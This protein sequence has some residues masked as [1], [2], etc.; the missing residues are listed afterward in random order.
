MMKK[1]TKTGIVLAFLLMLSALAV[2][3]IPA[4]E[5][6]LSRAADYDNLLVYIESD[7]SDVTIDETETITVNIRVSGVPTG[8]SNTIYAMG[9]YLRFD[10]AKFEYSKFNAANTF[11]SAER[12]L[13]SYQVST[14][15]VSE[16]ILLLSNMPNS[17]VTW[18][19]TGILASLVFNV[20]ADTAGSAVFEI[21]EALSVENYSHLVN[22]AGD[23]IP[24]RAS[25]VQ[26]KVVNITGG[27]EPYVPSTN[28]D[29]FSLSISGASNWTPVFNANTL[30]YSCT[31]P[32]TV[33]S[34]TVNAAA[35]DGL[36]SVNV[37][38]ADNLQVGS[39]SVTV[40]VTAE[41]GITTKTYS[42][43]VTRE[44]AAVIPS[45]NADLSSLSISGASSW[46]PTFSP[47]V[48]S[49]SCIVP[50]SMTN[51]NVIAA[52]A[53]SKAKV[54]IFDASDLQVG[55]N[56]VTVLVTAEDG[57]STKA[58][59]I[60]ITR[61]APP[62]VELSNNANLSSLS[63]NGASNWSPTF[64]PG[65]TGYSCTVPNS[66]A[67]VTVNYL[68]EQGGA[69]ASI[70]GANN[71]Q[72]G[73]NTVTVT[74][75]AEDGISKKTYTISVTREGSSLSNN[76]NL[77]SLSINNASNWSP[78]FNPSTTVY[79]C[80]VP[81]SI[82]NAVVN[83][84]REH[85]NATAN[86][87]GA[88][89]LQV[90]M[91]TVTVTVTAED[92]VATKIYTISVTREASSGTEKSNNA[93]LSILSIFGASNWSPSF[94]KNTTSYYCT[95]PNNISNV[96]VSANKEHANATVEIH[97]ANNLVVG[98]NTVTVL[99]T[100]ED[101][102]TKTYTI[103]VVRLESSGT[104]NPNN[105]NQISIVVKRGNSA[106]NIAWN[107]SSYSLMS[108]V[109]YEDKSSLT[110]KVSKL[111]P[112]YS[113]LGV[114]GSTAVW[115]EDYSL[116]LGIGQNFIFVSYDYNDIIYQYLLKIVVDE[117]V[118]NPNPTSP[119]G[120]LIGIVIKRNGVA[121]NIAR[122]GSTYSL[123]S[124]V[125]YVDR[126]NITVKINPLITGNAS[127][128]IDG[129]ASEWS[130]DYAVNLG[131]GQNIII[132]LLSYEDLTY[133]YLIKIIVAEDSSKAAPIENPS[134]ISEN[135]WLIIALVALG[136]IVILLFVRSGQRPVSY[137]I[138]ESSSPT[139]RKAKE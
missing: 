46:S 77:S 123:M 21:V 97:G 86:V 26:N 83:Y 126:N 63:I 14:S 138:V 11:P 76:A 45:A 118:G 16:G 23:E 87:S 20:T 8:N 105:L 120:N 58:Y 108:T 135:L 80:T 57:T 92:G 53:D 131:V 52:K 24:V 101:G 47:N 90:G 75:T 71:L 2:F 4:Q 102:T 65:T 15:M 29:L 133:Q 36:A 134:I 51:A 6:V 106:L 69:T 22:R 115:G 61:Q 12:I 84:T 88:N 73:F 60:N 32:N 104:E 64:N 93:N 111:F 114:D 55:L 124:E 82:V 19:E 91:N 48:L 125:A 39:N 67:S 34:L 112:E 117:P 110:L 70:S 13:I 98:P 81:N 116:N 31:V 38:G 78:T 121:Q 10:T 113:V 17:S 25:A 95:I 127:I 42:I 40:V 139:R 94:N 59:I 107:G 9:L 41:D 130:E 49:Y 74:V 33:S 132:V 119:S 85:G 137:P 129:A 72:V 103:S 43:N 99:V 128:S 54:E 3:S 122:N 50:N 27:T 5:P 35:E 66:T 136:I 68:L 89:S 96:T 109:A 62:G 30:S 28:A 1:F 18:K 44:P 100:A 37:V 7:P 56:T 79:S